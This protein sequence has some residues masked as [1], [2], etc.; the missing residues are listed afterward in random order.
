M[1]T[2]KV[3]DM[4]RPINVSV[5]AELDKIVRTEVMYL[6]INEALPKKQQ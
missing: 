1:M 5:E 4:A 3:L 2:N 6:L